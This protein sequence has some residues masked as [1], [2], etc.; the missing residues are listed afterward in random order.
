MMPEPLFVTAVQPKETDERYTPKWLFDAMG[1]TFD[2]DVCAPLEGV[3]WIPARA[4]YHAG[5]DGLAQPWHGLVWCNPP[6]SNTGPWTEKWI[7]HGNGVLLFPWSISARWVTRLLQAVP[8]VVR[9]EAFR[10]EHPTHTGRFV[11]V[12]IAL[13]ALGDG[14]PLMQ[15]VVDTGRGL[16][17]VP[18]AKVQQFDGDR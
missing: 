5:V 18:A 16:A 3:P 13:A 7:A 15:R 6:F 4:H 17:L 2:L 11:P 14:I 1:A 9:L 12:A 8:I 10:F